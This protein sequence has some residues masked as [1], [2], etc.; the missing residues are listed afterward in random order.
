[1]TFTTSLKEEISKND[2]NVIEARYELSAFLNSVAK[3]NKDEILITL[4]NA[5]IARMIYKEIKEI[6]GINPSIVVRI[7][8]RFKVKQIYILR[9]IER[10]DFIKKDI[11]VGIKINVDDLVSDEEKIAFIK[12]AFLAVGN[13]SNPSTSGY[14]LEFIFTKERLAKQ[15][16]N[17]LNYFNLKAKLIKRGYKNIVYIKA[18]ECISDLIKMFKATNSLFYFE[19]IRI[20]RDHKN[21]VNRL[22]NCEIAN[23]EKTFRTGQAQVESINYLIS[24]DLMGLLDENTRIVANARTK[25][26]EVSMQELADIVTLEYNYKI[27]KSGINHRFIKINN[28]VKNHKERSGNDESKIS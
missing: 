13:V 20:Y 4:E 23:Q 9:I 17:L 3:F 12:G 19:D 26:P 11:S 16:L 6:Y 8:K 27:G 2:I 22:N 21:M 5:S 18:S 25:Y 28:L 14:H 7:Q 1:M 24:H 10:I 15:V